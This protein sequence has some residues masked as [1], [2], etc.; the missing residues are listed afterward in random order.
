MKM[1][2]KEVFKVAVTKMAQA[3]DKALEL[4]GIKPNDLA[5]IIPHQA[6]LRIIDAIARRMDFPKEKVCITLNKD[7]N[8][9]AATTIVALDEARKEGRIKAGD[10]VEL[11]AFGGGFT[12]G[13]AVIRL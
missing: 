13:A 11:V 1:E 10:I 8:V 6:N 7:G 5:L 2:G 3:A 9:S 12:W 4:A